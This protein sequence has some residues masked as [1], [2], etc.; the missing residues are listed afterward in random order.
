MRISD[1]AQQTGCHLETVRYYERIG[2]LPQ[3]RRSASGYRQYTDAD[4]ERLRF[5]VRSRA[6]GFHLDE[7][8]SLLMLASES[9]LSCQ[10]VT[11][12]AREHLAQV[13]AKQQ[14]LARL[15][16]ELRGMIETCHND[17]RETCTILQ[18]LAG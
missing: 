2:L 10:D 13:E 17:T 15:A 12:L 16:S 7:I 11:A 4:M 8:R 18:S 6:L 3:P 9:S 14:E 5:I 1:L